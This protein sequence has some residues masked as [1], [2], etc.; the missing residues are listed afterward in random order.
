MRRAKKRVL[1]TFLVLVMT[2][3]LI[4]ANGIIARAEDSETPTETT[5]GGGTPE[6]TT[7]GEQEQKPDEQQGGEATDTSVATQTP[8][9]AGTEGEGQNDTQEPAAGETPAGQEQAA[10]PA[11]QSQ[12]VNGKPL[13]ITRYSPVERKWYVDASFEFA[14]DESGFANT[15]D[16]ETTTDAKNT[17]KRVEYIGDQETEIL[18]AVR[19]LYGEAAEAFLLKTDESGNRVYKLLELNVQEGKVCADVRL[20]EEEGKPLKVFLKQ[21]GANKWTPLEKTYPVKNKEGLDFGY[22]GAEVLISKDDSDILEKIKSVY[23]DE[24]YEALT[25]KK[26]G[27]DDRLYKCVKLSVQKEAVHVD[28]KYTDVAMYAEV[29]YD[30]YLV[31]KLPKSGGGL[32]W[33]PSLGIYTF[34]KDLFKQYNAE[35]LFATPYFEENHPENGISFVERV[36]SVPNLA[37]DQLT[38]WINKAGYDYS[39]QSVEEYG[40]GI[41]WNKISLMSDEEHW[42]VDG[43][44]VD[45]DNKIIG[46]NKT[47]V[48]LYQVKDN[49][50]T[51]LR[52]KV[53]DLNSKLDADLVAEIAN[54]LDQ[55]SEEGYNTP[56]WTVDDEEYAFE[57]RTL[58]KDEVE[59]V[60]T[61]NKKTEENET[62]EEPK[63]NTEGEETPTSPVTPYNPVMDTLE[64]NPT[65][66]GSGETGQVITEPTGENGNSTVDNGDTTQNEVITNG[67]K[68]EPQTGENVG[69]DEKTPE[70]NENKDENGETPQTNETVDDET[71]KDDV[72]NIEDGLVP[73]NETPDVGNK[74]D[75]KEESTGETPGA[76]T[77]DNGN[78]R[79]D[80]N[81]GSG[82]T[83]E[84]P[85]VNEPENNEAG[86]TPEDTKGDDSEVIVAD[87]SEGGNSGNS[88][89]VPNGEE[90]TGKD[91]K[92]NP[93]SGIS[94]AI[95]DFVAW[96]MALL[97]S[98]FTIGFAGATVVAKR[99]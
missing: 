89:V 49:V 60:V 8:Q 66:S 22:D 56:V 23:G 16:F 47:I 59:I 76:Q 94:A 85:V 86:E 44:I 9:P 21:Q 30:A 27:T 48:Q 42:H 57:E 61:L 31:K 54:G 80:Q 95:H 1:A 4:S 65:A 29:L 75:N 6:G 19:H 55:F 3:G 33:T 13:F 50:R 68:E 92:N 28:V 45:R 78:G 87:N 18:E 53:V 88:D 11:A 96:F 90:N 83:V 17:N 74:E 62:K 77:G 91:G 81:T 38:Q 20:A 73:G 70:G 46:K 14:P 51:H 40:I 7:E 24:A 43:R 5:G 39:Q 12:T 58:D 79:A 37:L 35:K 2:I 93:K 25:A 84:N 15:F 32:D 72:T 10:Q 63:E 67:D 71:A 69:G 82:E 97:A 26:E 98:I 99:R 41:D 36:A 34:D 52:S 64:E